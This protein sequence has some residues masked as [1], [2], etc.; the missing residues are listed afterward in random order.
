MA[1][2]V[3]LLN[4]L[5]IQIACDVSEVPTEAA[6]GRLVRRSS[7]KVVGLWAVRGRQHGFIAHE[8]SGNPVCR[9]GPLL[10]APCQGRL[11]PVSA[12]PKTSPVPIGRVYFRDLNAQGE[13]RDPERFSLGSGHCSRLM[14]MRDQYRPVHARGLRRPFGFLGTFSG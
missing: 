3:C 4:G 11:R 14:R 8:D 2:D 12:M 5:M 10:S 9:R 6:P 1:T 7:S 13:I